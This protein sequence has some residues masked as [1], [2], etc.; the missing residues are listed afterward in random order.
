MR[1]VGRARDLDVHMLV[2]LGEVGG[3]IADP[4]AAVGEHGGDLIDGFAEPSGDEA[5]PGMCSRASASRRLL[6]DHERVGLDHGAGATSPRPRPV[7]ASA[8]L[9]CL[10][11][12]A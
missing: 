5:S 3:G 4:L 7:R 10:G 9:G 12:M 2:A 1:R 6:V 11:T 8:P